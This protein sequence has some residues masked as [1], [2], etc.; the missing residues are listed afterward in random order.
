MFTKLKNNYRLS[1]V[2][3]RIFFVLAFVFAKWQTGLAA[4]TLT[5]SYLQTSLG[6]SKLFVALTTV[7]GLGTGLM[8]LL[9][10]IVNAILNFAKI[11]SVPRNEYC[12]FAHVFCALGYF[13]CG[14]LNLIN[15]FTPIF[16]VWG[17]VLFPFVSS[18]IAALL[19]YKVTAKLYFNSSTSVYYFKVFAIAYL[20]IVLVLEVLA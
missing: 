9:P 1:N 14:A 4:A 20:V 12:L 6:A 16:A 19:F 3:A 10:V 15:V 11:Y 7:A 8:F 13:I 18:L 5:E 2:L 17:R